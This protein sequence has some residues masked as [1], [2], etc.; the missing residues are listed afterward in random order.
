MGAGFQR[1]TR[2][3]FPDLTVALFKRWLDE[4]AAYEQELAQDEE[5]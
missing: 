4:V 2:L 1:V 3:T 5:E